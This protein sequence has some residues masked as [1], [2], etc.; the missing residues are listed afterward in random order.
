V[1]WLRE[2][3]NVLVLFFT[4]V[5]MMMGFGMVI[6]ILPFYVRS[7]GASGNEL[8]LLMA[9]FATMQFIFAPFWGGLSDRHGR[10]PIIMLGVL[11]NAL[12]QLLFGLS[13]ELWMLFAT[14]ALAGILSSATLPTAMAYIGDTSSHQDRA[15]RMGMIGAAMGVGMVIGPG[16]GGWLAG[17]SL[18]APFFAASALSL[19]VLVLVLLLVPESLPPAART[20]AARGARGSRL[21]AMVQAVAGPTGFLF[22]LAFLLSF[23]LASFEGIFGLYAAQRYQYGPAQVGTIMTLIGVIS[24]VVQ[25]GLVGPLSRRWGEAAI[26]RASLFC[27]SLGFLLMLLARTYPGVLVTVGLFVVSNTMLTPS[28]SSLVSKRAAVGQ[29][30]AMGLN[31]SFMSLGRIVGPIWAGLLF[32]VSMAL[33]YLSGS[34]IMALTFVASLIWL[35]RLRAAPA[36]PS[37]PA[38]QAFP[39]G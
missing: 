13:T 4:L 35:P 23:G 9:T 32:D 7:F 11:G 20:H 34:L 5:V 12:S 26:I 36:V 38:E 18:S 17:Y 8:G 33:P 6:P 39:D 30:T 19:V 24:A 28:V 3:R 10:K 22:V 15:G 1:V 16:I 14:R 29:G 31:N 27:T 25:G 21:R 37:L 2:Q